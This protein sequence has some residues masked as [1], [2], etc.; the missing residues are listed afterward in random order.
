MRARLE[1]EL[2]PFMY[3]DHHLPI[4]G[5]PVICRRAFCSREANPKLTAG[6][7][8]LCSE[9]AKRARRDRRV[10]NP[11]RRIRGGSVRDCH[12]DIRFPGQPIF[13][14]LAIN[15]G[16]AKEGCDALGLVYRSILRLR[17]EGLSWI[18]ADRWATVMGL[19]PHEIWG[20]LWDEQT[21]RIGEEVS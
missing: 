7:A 19:S 17:I 5:R 1:G 18:Q 6:D 11:L 12:P 10:L 3:H 8:G 15:Y 4:E 2:T 16:S 14:W 21:S 20:Q 13:D 9:C